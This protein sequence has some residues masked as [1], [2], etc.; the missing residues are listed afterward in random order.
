MDRPLPA[1]R[2]APGRAKGGLAAAWLLAAALALGAP[3]A[4]GQV[5]AEPPAWIAA[6]GASA[7]RVE[8]PVFGGNAMVY[9]AGP[10]G[11]D[12]IVLVHGLGPSGAGIWSK[13]IPALAARHE[14]FAL[15]LPGF[16]QSDKDNQLYS[17]ANFARVIEFVLAKRIDRPFTLVGHSL[18]GSV[19]IAYAAAYPRRVS[20]LVVVDAAGVL[21]RAVY[22]EFLGRSAAQLALGKTPEGAP[23][24]DSFVRTVLTRAEPLPAAGRVVLALPELRQ[25]LLRGEPQA[26]AA[27][28]LVEHDFSRDLRSIKT[29]T[30]VIWGAEDKVASLRT[31]R[32]AAALI[33]GAR[34]VVM[35]RVAHSP[36]LEVPEKF[37]ALVLDELEGRLR[38]DS[39]AMQAGAPGTRVESCDGRREPHSFSG[40]YKEITLSGCADVQIMNARIGTLVSRNSVVRLINS[41]VYE[42]I[43]A[44]HSRLELTAGMVAG[45]PPLTLEETGVDAAGTRFESRGPVAENRGKL[46][47]TVSFSVS[48]AAGVKPRYLHEVVRLPAPRARQVK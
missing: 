37:S 19:S 45:E 26:I 14:V 43:D 23:W 40:D 12:T 31:G 6:A 2:A 10:R 28:A 13:V 35:D 47:L 18:G 11:A 41:H 30:L 3:S 17:P 32:L 22:A 1:A 9:R 34:L 16:G 42:G 20:R 5:S 21:H 8:E 24:F 4:I 15:D 36:M 44:R 46:P 29:P 33:P 39:Y 25:Q 27:Y 7:E 38:L 48:E